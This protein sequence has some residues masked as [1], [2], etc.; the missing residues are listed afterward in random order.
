[1][2]VY[3]SE[4]E[5][6]KD[7]A[8]PE[9]LY[10][11]LPGIEYGNWEFGDDHDGTIIYKNQIQLTEHM[12]NNGSIYLHTFFTEAGRSPNPADKETY[13]KRRTFS[14]FKRRNFHI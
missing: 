1:M 9:S 11:Y 2:Y 10:W 5:K 7:F 14:T 12:Q 6:F 4:S 13:S 3:L 8:N